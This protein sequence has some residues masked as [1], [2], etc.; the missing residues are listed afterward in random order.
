[1]KENKAISKIF[2]ILEWVVT[3]GLL[4]LI[5]LV[6]I[7]K[8]SE[9]GNFFGYRIYI[10]ASG[11]MIPTYNIGDT[12]LVKEVPMEEFEIG[13]AVT[14]KGETAGVDGIVITHQVQK[15]EKDDK[16]QYLFH[17]KGIANNIED[18]VVYEKQVLG[19]VTHKFLI[20]SI[21]GRVITN[22]MLLL[23]CIMLP[24]AF[25]VA[26]EIIKLVYRKDDDE[27]DELLD[28]EN[29][30]E[31]KNKKTNKVKKDEKDEKEVEE[32][33]VL[34]EKEELVESSIEIDKAKEEELVEKI[35]EKLKIEFE[36]KLKE[37]E[38][39]KETK[40]SNTNKKKYYQKNNQNNK[41]NNT[42]N[43]KQKKNAY[44]AQ[45]YKQNNKKN[46]YKKANKK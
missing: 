6:G 32:Q 22:R 13:D 19:K 45:Y 20:L 29:D 16:G 3:A 38:K 21:L 34:E 46:Y 31:E 23:L 25:L 11:S 14:Y 36:E 40:K 41:A 1:M 35:R 24:M 12:L 10:V 18:P 7:Q 9:A 37:I 30:K 4:L 2:D 15:I 26:I 8:F 27:F 42:Q 43:N 39:K 17:T 33:P 28:V 5:V 44:K